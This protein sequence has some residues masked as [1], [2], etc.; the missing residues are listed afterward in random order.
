MQHSHI[1]PAFAYLYQILCK[2]WRHISYL[3]K[4]YTQEHTLYSRLTFIIAANRLSVKNVNVSS[5]PF[6]SLQL[7]WVEGHK[8][9]AIGMLPSLE[10]LYS[11]HQHSWRSHGTQST[12]T[13]SKTATKLGSSAGGHVQW[14]RRGQCS[15][16]A[17]IPPNTQ[18]G[19]RGG[20]GGGGRGGKRTTTFSLLLLPTSPPPPILV[21]YLP[22]ISNHIPHRGWC[23][24]GCWN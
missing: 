23:Q 22:W 4:L 5:L 2:I 11:S 16:L 19:G 13:P 3:G 1:S 9:H 20:E 12:L 18:G 24:G 21:Y 10:Q 14:S 8:M 6:S 17:P 15:T 7:W